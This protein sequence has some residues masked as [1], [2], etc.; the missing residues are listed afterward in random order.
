MNIRYLSKI[1]CAA[2]STSI[3]LLHSCSS[4][5]GTIHRGYMLRPFLIGQKVSGSI[6]AV[7]LSNRAYMMMS[8][9]ERKEEAKRIQSRIDLLKKTIKEDF[10]VEKETLES[11]RN[12]CYRIYFKRLCP[13]IGGM[14]LWLAATTPKDY[15]PHYHY[16]QPP[17]PWGPLP[18][19]EMGVWN[20]PVSAAAMILLYLSPIVMAGLSA[21]VRIAHS[22]GKIDAALYEC[23]ELENDLS[24]HLK[25]IKSTNDKTYKSNDSEAKLAIGI[26][27]LQAIK[28]D[29]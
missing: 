5:L 26:A 16:P 1:I 29:N 22:Q 17:E 2:L 8:L 14:G 9:D 15:H 18:Y 4:V 7:R 21:E 24:E 27:H 10:T 19:P 23:G 11:L 13:M 28:K 25:I 3:T 20:Y 12:G 6:H